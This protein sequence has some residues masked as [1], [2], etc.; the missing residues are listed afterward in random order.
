MLEFVD[1]VDPRF[2]REVLQ[3]DIKMIKVW[4][5]EANILRCFEDLFDL[6]FMPTEPNID[7][8]DSMLKQKMGEHITFYQQLLQS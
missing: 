7:S 1:H 4:R 2:Q 8:A 5:A 3:K 6:K